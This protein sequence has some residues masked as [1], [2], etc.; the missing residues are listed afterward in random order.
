MGNI[1]PK[2]WDTTITVY[3][4]FEDAQTHVV[5][6]YRHVIEN[7]F[8]EYQSN[9]LTIGETVLE[10]NKIVCRIRRNDNFLEVY[11]YRDIPNDQKD[12]Y[13]TLAKGDVIVKG[14]VEDE[15]DEYTKGQRSSDL[16]K[17]YKNLQGCME[18]DHVSI[19]AYGGRAGM[20]EHYLAEGL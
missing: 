11:Q 15:I 8:W 16:I 10:S 14:E 17:K 4:R 1:Y 9:K 18:I 19:N 2:W 3:N 13:F 7:C 6:W 5:T 20:M 12:N